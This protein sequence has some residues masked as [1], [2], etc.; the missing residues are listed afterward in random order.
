MKRLILFFVLSFSGMM[1]LSAQNIEENAAVR[2]AL[3]KMLERLD[4]TK[5]PTGLLLDYAFD[6][7]DFDR[8]DGSALT[9]SNY[10]ERT[11]FECLLRSV[12]SSAVGTKPFGDVG[13]IMDEMSRNNGNTL[14]VGLLLFK[15]NYIREDA[16]DNNL[17]R[18]ENDKVY[19]SYGPDGKWRNPYA[20][21]YVIG[22]SS[23][24]FASFS[25]VTSFSF[26]SDFIFSN[27]G[28][29]KME[30]DPGDGS[31]Y[32]RISAGSTVS[33]SYQE[34]AA[35][36]KMRVTLEDGEVLTCHSRLICDPEGIKLQGESANL[37]KK[38]PDEMKYFYHTS[39][40]TSI[41]ART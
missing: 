31:G 6:L 21:K 39:G 2:D 16:L 17:I 38:H 7:V 14:N 32:R 28:I 34:G 19:D 4:K 8:Y 12:R 11:T 29:V 25:S 30:F 1:V 41:K 15:Y 37:G 23:Y 10:V 27:T 22:F 18:Y 26:P 3:D 33:A 9:D 40:G 35:E 36:L 5:V 24:N 13:S 20:E